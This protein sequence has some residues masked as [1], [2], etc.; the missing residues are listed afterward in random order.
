MIRYQGVNLRPPTPQSV[1]GALLQQE[2]TCIS[3][4][5]ACTTILTPTQGELCPSISP[6]NQALCHTQDPVTTPVGGDQ[7]GDHRLPSHAS[8]KSVPLIITATG[9]YTH[10]MKEAQTAGTRQKQNMISGHCWDPK[11]ETMLQGISYKC[12]WHSVP[13]PR[14]STSPLSLSR[15]CSLH[16]GSTSSSTDFKIE[17]SAKSVA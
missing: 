6:T 2:H 1:R 14:E 10:K 16:H 5:A 17:G 3:G 12:H 9:T 4:F 13:P 11:T 8:S 7:Q 15:E